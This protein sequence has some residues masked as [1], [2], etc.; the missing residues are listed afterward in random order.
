MIDEK[1]QRTNKGEKW[2]GQITGHCLVI[3]KGLQ[4]RRC[5]APRAELL[6]LVGANRVVAVHTAFTCN[7]IKTRLKACLT[8]VIKTSKNVVHI[9]RE[10]SAT[11][12][13]SA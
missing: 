2:K 4:Q 8:M 9:E 13:H 10:K 3:Q 12:E 7:A 11:V 6:P 1:H 5:C